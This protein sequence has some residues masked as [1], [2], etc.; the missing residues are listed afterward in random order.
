MTKTMAAVMLA[1]LAAGACGGS[2]A[3]KADKPAAAGPPTVDVVTVIEKPI[4][5]T[6]ALPG[7]LDAFESVAMFPKVT[8]FVKTIRVDRGSRVR[9]GEILVTLDAPELRAQRSEAQSR[10]QAVEAQLASARAR[11]EASASTYDRLKAASATPGVVAGNELLQAQKAVESDRSQVAAAEQNVAA[12]RQAV[13]SV[14]DV[15]AYLQVTAPFAGI[16]TERNVHPGALVG[17]AGGAAGGGT[18]MLRLADES[19]LRLSIAVPEA[20]A[21]TITEGA[22]IPFTVAA[23]P[24]QPFSG[25]IARVAHAIDVRTRTMSVELDVANADG[26]LAPGTYCQVKWPVRRDKPSLL[27]PS[28]SVASTTDRTFVVR[29][30]DGRTEWVDVKTGL[31]TGSMVEVF[32]DLHAGDQVAARGTDELK[33]GSAVT[34]RTAKPA[35]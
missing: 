5:L 1:A 33:A 14:T 28:A 22:A 25:H 18:P 4:E 26:R 34:P 15:E 8:G 20:Y 6:L 3:A 7:E 23:F 24:G 32:G 27:V 11:G 31:T 9:A 19:K 17:P 13:Q 30:R 21:G 12:A 29:V 35:S 10:L 16:V 2:P